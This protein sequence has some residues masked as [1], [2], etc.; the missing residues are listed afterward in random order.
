MTRLPE[1]KIHAL[2]CVCP[3]DFCS[4]SDTDYRCRDLRAAIA[5]ALD[6]A[7]NRVIKAA[8]QGGRIH[9]T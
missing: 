6:E 2:R 8:N 7:V 5:E 1:K 3:R 4:E 9:R